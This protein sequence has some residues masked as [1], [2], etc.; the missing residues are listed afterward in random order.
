M[1][2]GSADYGS[3]FGLWKLGS[4]FARAMA[5]GFSGILLGHIGLIPGQPPSPPTLEKIGILFGPGVGLFFIAGAVLVLFY[6]LK[7]KKIMQ[8]QRILRRRQAKNA[9]RAA[10]H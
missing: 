1:K 6:P 10:E 7:H 2:T 9:N 8:L 5:I 4:K 3:Y